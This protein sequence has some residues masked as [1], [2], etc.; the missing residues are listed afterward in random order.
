MLQHFFTSY[1]A[2]KETNLKEN[3]VK[4]MEPYDPAEPLARL[5]KQL[6]KGIE[7]VRAG[8]QMISGTM[9]VFKGITLLE[10]TSTFNEDIREW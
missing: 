7:F 4:M 5:I 9:M 6:E 2:I 10:Q 8:G 3:T 1:E